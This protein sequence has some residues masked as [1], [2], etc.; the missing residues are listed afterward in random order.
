MGGRGSAYWVR[1][2]GVVWRVVCD[3]VRR[4]G[5]R[6]VKISVARYWV[7]CH[8]VCQRWDGGRK[9]ARG[10]VRSGL[11]YVYEVRQVL[12]VGV[13][14]P[15]VAVAGCGCLVGALAAGLVRLA[16]SWLGVRERG[17]LDYGPG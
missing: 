16:F 10:I 9:W 8:V 11:W 17:S 6:E 4:A 7:L 15:V 12:C 3:R 1:R 14:V 5:G 2:E 13:M